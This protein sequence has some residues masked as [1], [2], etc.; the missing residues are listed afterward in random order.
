MFLLKDLFALIAVITA[1]ALFALVIYV[2]LAP[3]MVAWAVLDS[4]EPGDVYLSTL[5][6]WHDAVQDKLAAWANA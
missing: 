2:F 5:S 3:A 6:A 1:F 4:S